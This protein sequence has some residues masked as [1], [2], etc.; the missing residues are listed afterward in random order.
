MDVA[1][2]FDWR[3]WAVVR[4]QARVYLRNWYTALLPPVLEPILYLMAFGLGLG[5][6]IGSLTWSGHVV[7]YL[8]Y[9]APGIVTYTAFNGPFFQGLYGAFVRMHYQKTWEGQLGTQVELTHVVAGEMLWAALQGTVYAAIVC[10]VLLVISACGFVHLVWWALPACLPIAFVLGCAVAL[11]GL[12]FTAIMPSI[13]HMNL[14]TFLVGFPVGVLSDTYFPVVAKAAWL[15]VLV[16]L[17]PVHH[18][19]ESIRGLLLLGRLDHHVVYLVL[20]CSVMVLVLFPLVVRLM[21][22][23]VLG[24]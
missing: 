5:S 16:G 17:N 22:R 24:E 7:P 18:A 3:A 23:R 4:R 21:R 11:V 12:F 19:A 2:A 9:M 13:D 15:R 10:L 1:A 14:P 8:A 6:Y 20:I